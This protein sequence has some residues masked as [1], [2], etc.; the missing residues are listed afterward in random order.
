MLKKI[1]KKTALAL[2]AFLT[3]AIFLLKPFGTSPNQAAILAAIFAGIVCWTLEL[4][5]KILSSAILV[6]V[7]LFLNSAPLDKILSF[8]LSATFPMIL[9][10]YLFSRGI[11]NSGVAK[12]VIDP[13]LSKYANTPLRIIGL[14]I[15]TL[16]LTIRVIPQPLARLIMLAEI[17]A[18]FLN[19]TNAG[20]RLKQILMYSLF[21]FYIIVNAGSLNA[22]IILN[23]SALSFS[24]TNMDSAAWFKS[25]MPPTVIYCALAFVLFCVMYRKDLTGVKISLSSQEMAT[26]GNITLTRRQVLLILITGATILLWITKPLHG[27]SEN[28]VSLISVAALFLAGWLAP[29]DLDSIDIATLVFLTAANAIGSAMTYSG[30]AQKLLAGL[31]SIF[32]DEFSVQYVLMIILV[33]MLLHFLLGSNTTALSVAIPG[34]MVICGNTVSSNVLTLTAYMS[35]IPHHLLP[36]HCIGM[37][38]GIGNGYFKPKMVLDVGLPMMFMIVIAILGIYIPWWKIIGLL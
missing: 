34:L 30:T 13:L 18:G 27:V 8:P 14:M 6:A 25:M 37:A 10:C 19:R 11:R 1:N 2:T 20:D 29:K 9:L 16:A 35:L 24:G 7:L 32:P 3:I 5:S 12:A 21:E 23:T 15:L 4:C 17:F 33:T 38:I 22:D 26:A 28:I 36:F 31:E